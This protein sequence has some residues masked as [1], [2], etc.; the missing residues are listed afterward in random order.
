MDFG[1]EKSKQWVL[2][3]LD[4]WYVKRFDERY[5]PEFEHRIKSSLVEMMDEEN[6]P[7]E[8]REGF[9]TLI[10]NQRKIIQESFSVYYNYL[11]NLSEGYKSGN[12]DS[13]PQGFSPK[14]LELMLDGFK[15][16]H[17]FVDETRREAEEKFPDDLTDS[18]IEKSFLKTYGNWRGYAEYIQNLT[19]ITYSML[20]SLHEQK[21]LDNEE[22]NTILR[23]M[24]KTQGLLEII[25]ERMFGD[26]E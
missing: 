3:R 19:N 7:E 6:F 2:K 24:G 22:Y 15:K 8:V 12:L 25:C 26:L 1:M 5:T 4:E 10:D 18:D 14:S 9:L 17:S 13:L 16:L 23:I 20:E 21:Q 11:E